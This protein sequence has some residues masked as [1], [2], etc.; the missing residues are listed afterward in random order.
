MKDRRGFL[1]TIG[2]G[3]AAAGPLAAAALA[4]PVR[5]DTE[6][7]ITQA[8]MEA[9]EAPATPEQIEQI[10]EDIRRTAGRF[11]DT[12]VDRPEFI[13]PGPYKFEHRPY[14]ETPYKWAKNNRRP[15]MCDME[16]MLTFRVNGRQTQLKIRNEG[17]NYLC[18]LMFTGREAINH[19][20]FFLI[21]NA[22]FTAMCHDDTSGEHAGWD[23]FV[24]YHYMGRD[25]FRPE[26]HPMDETP[27]T[28]IMTGTGTI[29]GF[30]IIGG[31]PMTMY[32]GDKTPNGVLFSM[33]LFD[34][35]IP[36]VQGD[37]LTISHE[38]I[39]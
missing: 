16:D 2:L 19:W 33:G 35:D 6:E 39:T 27:V 11:Y 26:W 20:R 23:E 17:V 30:G 18:D 22:G 1:K 9:A 13:S 5:D 32:K 7:Q 24:D 3:A 14:L 37:H 21:D 36:V 15:Y 28:L 29:K 34:A 8:L 31:N 10:T 38:C 4:A 25:F 12:G